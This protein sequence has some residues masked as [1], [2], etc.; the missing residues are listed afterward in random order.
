MM[1]TH[2]MKAGTPSMPTWRYTKR[3]QTGFT[4]VELMIA[5]AIVGVLAAIAYP[6]YEEHL[7]KARRAEG[8]TALMKAAQLQERF[9]TVNARYANNNELPTLFGLPNGAA[10]HSAE[11]PADATAP[12]RITVAA[13]AGCDLASCFVL[14]ATPNGNFTDAQCGNLTL[15]STELRDRS[16]SAPMNRCW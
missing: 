6:A 13:G 2:A 8:K 14:T 5:I 9:Y 11:N 10:L 4:L 12:Y 16:G 1:S 7:R 3:T 15:T